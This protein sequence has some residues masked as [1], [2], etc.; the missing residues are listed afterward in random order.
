[1]LSEI[2]VKK[3]AIRIE[4]LEISKIQKYTSVACAGLENVNQ[5]ELELDAKIQFRNGIS[6]EGIQQT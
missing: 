3:R 4:I 2:K 6:T 5:S 1:M